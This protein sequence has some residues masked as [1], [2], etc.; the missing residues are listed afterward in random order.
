MK[1][2]KAQIVATIGPSSKSRAV[3]ENMMKHQMD[4][5]RLNFS[6]GTLDEHANYIKDVREVAAKL[7]KRIPI[8]QDLPGPRIQMKKGHK[9]DASFR[10]ALTD[11][12]LKMLRFGITQNID[13]VAMSYVGDAGDIEQLK[14]EMERRGASIPIIAK[15]ERKKALDN[16]KEI[17]K[18][19]DGIM[20]ARGDLGNEI[21]IEKIPFAQRN[22]IEATRKTKKPVIVA[23]QMLLSMVENPLPTRAEVTDVAHAIID[24]ADGVMLSEETA[25]GKYP[26]E[27]VQIMERIVLEAERH[28][29][30][31]KVFVI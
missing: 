14:K 24:G 3:L 22:I 31:I 26:V 5:A 8:I 13:Y 23:T 7:K 2:S 15:I 6:W 19:A 10:R 17:I 4:V 29:G 20:V 9:R 25:T 27:A 12:D 1:K 30:A 28:L 18:A 11:N 16:L 21:P